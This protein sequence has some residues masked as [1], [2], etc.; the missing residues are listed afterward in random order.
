MMK[1]HIT[2]KDWS[3]ILN[4]TGSIIF[5][6]GFTMLIPMIIA[7]FSKE[8]NSFINFTIGFLLCFVSGYILR[9]LFKLEKETEW[10]H[11]MSA[12]TISW[13]IA[14]LFGAVP[15]YL[16][17]FF[18]SYLDACFDT[19]SGLTTTGLFTMQNI[20]HAPI[21]INIW[22][23]VLT[24]IGGQGIVVIALAF[25]APLGGLAFKALV[26]EGK[27]ERLTPSMR[28]TG[29]AIWFIS[30]IYLFIATIGYFFIGLNMGLKPG[31]SLFH[32]VCAFMSAWST[33]G[34]GPQSQN[35]LYYHSFP[36]EIIS[37]IFMIIGSMNFG[38]HY[39]V[40]FKN[41]KELIK[42]IEI[43]SFFVTC[44]ITFVLLLYGL[45]KDR[46]YTTFLPLIRKSLFILI[47]GHT[48]TGNQTIYSVQFVTH[49]GSIGLLAII[50]AM[51]FGGSSAS[52][53]GGFKGL[54]IG[55][56][57]KATIAEIKKYFLPPGGVVVEKFNHLQENVLSDKVVRSAA[58]IVIL[59]ILMHTVGTLVGVM[60]GYPVIQSLFE[61]ISAGSNT[62]LSCGITSTLMPASMKI[63][64]IMNMWLGRLEFI[65]V[66]VFIFL[67]FRFFSRPKITFKSSIRGIKK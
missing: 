35:T 4:L 15:Y 21:S 53:A 65:A 51:A 48:T 54:R 41:K 27:E 10:I 44:T 39:Y 50:L 30:L 28:E 32:G 3:I 42:D 22:R 63:T 11:G 43:K 38:L 57:F 52:T 24:F 56:L 20:D 7:I 19:M 16:S 33:G 55:I 12:T 49:W 6:F 23:H 61:S 34:F 17:G 25:L 5:Y 64:Y 14:M 46:I 37:M 47:S 59:Y 66:F 1:R 26:G 40:W 45:I 8:Y 31:W 29:K 60:N 13:L 58:L 9:K 62:G 18:R 2:F 67:I 36:F